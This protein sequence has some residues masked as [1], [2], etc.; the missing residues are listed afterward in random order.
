MNRAGSLS[1]TVA[2]SFWCRKDRSDRGPGYPSSCGPQLQSKRYNNTDPEDFAPVAGEVNNAD[3]NFPNFYRYKNWGELNSTTMTAQVIDPDN[4][5]V[6]CSGT[7]PI[8]NHDEP[9]LISFGLTAACRNADKVS[10]ATIHLALSLSRPG[11]PGGWWITDLID[12]FN[13][14]LRQYEFSTRHIPPYLQTHPFSTDRVEALRQRVSQAEHYG[15]QDTPDNIR[16]FQ[17]M[18]AKLIG[19]IQNQ[20]Q[21][22][23]RYP[24]TDHSQPARYAR[25]VAYYRVADLPSARAE[26]NSLI[27]ED[28]NNPYFQELMGQILFE[29]GH[30]A[31]SVP[32]HRRSV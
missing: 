27:A 16:R 28:P 21:T 26:L 13:K 14:N 19:F 17:F 9:R 25:A 11:V 32:F 15:A 10:R 20:G 5:S 4:G 31:E 23:A 30:A 7:A 12:F 6:M 8:S 22:M 29:N 3:P 18:Q 1:V 2:G 24:L